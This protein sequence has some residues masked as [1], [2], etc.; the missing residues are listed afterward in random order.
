M[1]KSVI[2]S[3]KGNVIKVLIFD[4]KI[5]IEVIKGNIRSYYFK[6]SEIIIIGIKIKCSI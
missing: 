2:L 4:S 5:G 1:Y 6:I 3:I